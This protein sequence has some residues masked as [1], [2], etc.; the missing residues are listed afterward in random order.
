MRFIP[1]AIRVRLKL[2]FMWQGYPN[3]E[4]EN[5]IGMIEHGCF[6]DAMGAGAPAKEPTRWQKFCRW[7][8]EKIEP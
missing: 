7:A 2:F 6:C 1:M 4:C 3:Y 8:A 5:C